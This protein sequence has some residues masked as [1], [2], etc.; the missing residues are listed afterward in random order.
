MQEGINATI[1]TL[2]IVDDDYS[3]INTASIVQLIS[4][5]GRSTVNGAYLYSCYIMIPCE[6]LL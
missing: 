3:D 6:W 2:N 4:A 1:T 5:T